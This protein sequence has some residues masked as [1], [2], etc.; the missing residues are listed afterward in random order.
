MDCMPSAGQPRAAP[1]LALVKAL[2]MA[3]DKVPTPSSGRIP[4]E[5]LAERNRR[6]KGCRDSRDSGDRTRG[7]VEEVASRVAANMVGVVTTIT[8]AGVTAVV[9]AGKAHRVVVW[10]RAPPRG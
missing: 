2:L 3:H 9:E 6:N 5:E 8:A 10:L 7:A 4:E 1:T